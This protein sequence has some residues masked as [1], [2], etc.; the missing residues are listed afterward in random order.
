MQ[1]KQKKCRMCPRMFTPYDSMQVCCSYP[2]EKKR[3]A[4]KNP[5]KYAPKPSQ[6]AERVAAKKRT[7]QRDGYRCML[8][9]V[10]RHNKHTSSMDSHH[11]IYLSEGGT[12]DDWNLIT[13]CSYCHHHVVH[14]DKGWQPRL[15]RI[16]GGL[17]W[18]ENIDKESLSEAVLKK[19]NYC[20]AILEENDTSSDNIVLL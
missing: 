1:P 10:A 8:Y 3:L 6:P 7:K 14:R 17:N 16:V 19:L 11:I 18:Y 12:D 13:L 4:E 20:R 9:W 2:C 15:L 5:K